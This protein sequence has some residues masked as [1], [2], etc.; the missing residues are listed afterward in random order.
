M[1]CSAFI[2]EIPYHKLGVLSKG[3]LAWQTFR[4]AG[5]LLNQPVLRDGKW[6]DFSDTTKILILLIDSNL[7]N[8][9]AWCPY[10][11]SA[12]IGVQWYSEQHVI[13]KTEH[14]STQINV[15]VSSATITFLT[16]L[17]QMTSFN[18]SMKSLNC[19]ACRG[20]WKELMKESLSVNTNGVDSLSSLSS[21]LNWNWFASVS[22]PATAAGTQKWFP[23][24]HSS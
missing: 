23:T 13:P 5:R 11:Q 18:G 22:L 8:L 19:K 9:P 1:L 3:N 7:S 15:S 4:V 12:Y 17:L 20:T 24:L 14:H 16:S 2:L 6:L 10:G 21:V